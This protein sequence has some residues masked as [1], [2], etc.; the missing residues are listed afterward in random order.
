[1]PSKR[2]IP[3]VCR[4]CGS[5]FL[6]SAS[7]VNRGGGLYCDRRCRVA[8]QRAGCT[9]IVRD[10][11]TAQIPLR[12]RGG[13]VRAY[14]II[15]AADAEWASQWA[16]HLCDGYAR[17]LDFERGQPQVV[18]LH[19]AL[20]GLKP[21]DGFEGD[22]IDR[23]RLNCQRHNLRALPEQGRPN[24]Q[25]VPGRTGHSS[26]YRGVSWD[27]AVSKW[28]AKVTVGGQSHNIGYFV[29]EE[30]AA[31]AAQAARS[32]LMPFATD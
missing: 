10:D 31:Q 1:M 29:D 20:L 32:R 16:W 12:G 6:A 2:T 5:D 4:A 3:R 30:E 14:A 26:P 21:G 22:H 27:R 18:K 15:D 11:G 7:E 23:D 24:T 19:R 9:P 8:D 17:R 25:N 13:T 28:R